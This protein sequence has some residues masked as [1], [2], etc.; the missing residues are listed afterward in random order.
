MGEDSLACV[1]AAYLKRVAS[2][3]QALFDRLTHLRDGRRKR[4]EVSAR[5]VEK[6]MHLSKDAETAGKSRLVA[7]EHETGPTASGPADLGHESNPSYPEPEW[8]EKRRGLVVDA[9]WTRA[10]GCVER[11][12]TGR[13]RKTRHRGKSAVRCAFTVMASA[14][15][16]L[17]IEEPAGQA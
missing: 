1:I 4:H 3:L 16:L 9:R 6:L 17:R 5:H 12:P 14:Y 13:M 11:E 15:H 8:M 7:R 10:D 2:W